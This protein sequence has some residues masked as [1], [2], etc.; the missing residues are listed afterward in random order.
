MRCSSVSGDPQEPDRRTTHPNEVY[1]LVSEL[2][3]A[4]YLPDPKGR[5]NRIE[6]LKWLVLLPSS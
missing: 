2:L 5:Q 3:E 6:K 4:N 1:S